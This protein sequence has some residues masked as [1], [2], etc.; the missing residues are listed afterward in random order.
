MAWYNRLW[1]SITAGVNAA[2]SEWSAIHMTPNQ[3]FDSEDWDNVGFRIVRYQMADAMFHNTVYDKLNIWATKLKDHYRLYKHIR[4]IYNPVHRYVT[5]MT[6]YMFGGEIDFESLTDGALPISADDERII[7]G[8]RQLL[9]DSR[10]QQRKSLYARQCSLYGD[11]FIHVA[12]DR[13]RQ[14]VYFEVLHPSRVKDITTD[15]QGNIQYIMI[16]Y[17]RL[18]ND[19]QPHVYTMV[20]T[21]EMYQTF[22]DGEPFAYYADRSGTLLPEWPN[23]Y[24]FVPVVHVP[25][26]DIGKK[27]GMTG[28]ASSLPKIHE[29]NDAASLLNDNIRKHVNLGFWVSGG[30]KGDLKADKTDRHES[31]MLLYGQAGSTV[32]PLVSPID[33]AGALSNLDSQL[34]EIE[35]DL[36]SLALQRIRENSSQLTA[37]GVRTAYSDAIGLIREA[38]G[39]L[40]DGIVRASKM[41]LSIGGYNGYDGYQG[42]DLL[43]YERD[44]LDFHIRPHPVIADQLTAGEEMTA[45]QSLNT[46]K[47][48]VLILRKLNYSDEEIAEIENEEMENRERQTREAIARLSSVIRGDDDDE[49]DGEMPEPEEDEDASAA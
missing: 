35:R 5:L 44:E 17:T 48:D 13:M 49:D 41:A 19:G 8:M 34:R 1:T 45:L 22:R 16:E 7:D 36:P 21:P 25:F 40:G 14:M 29:L 42:F 39:N 4:S 2:L 12:D 32:T 20:I 38:R 18:D 23:E 31:I 46:S 26:D 30:Q 24:G 10:W 28:Y 27:F 3:M 11:T 43:S 9:I 33:I 15:P 37:P 47:R 6:A